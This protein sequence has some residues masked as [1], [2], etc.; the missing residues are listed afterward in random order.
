MDELRE[1]YQAVILDHNKNPKNFREI[2]SPTHESDGHN[3]LC[4]DRV[5]VYLHV[6]ESQRIQD[7]SFQGS[8]CAISKAS[9]SVMTTILKG[10]TVEEAKAEFDTFQSLITGSDSEEP[11]IDKHG[12]LAAFVGVR[13]FPMRVKC[14]TLAWHTVVAA[15]DGAKQG[16]S[17]E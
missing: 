11:D 16:V 1:L 13:E 4:G 6:D 14:A 8:G 7:I 12:Q 3:P 10:K 2:E 15:L 17:T 5:H 9:S